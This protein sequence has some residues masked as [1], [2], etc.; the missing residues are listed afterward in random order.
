MARE[1]KVADP[2]VFGG[3]PN[4]PETV[5]LRADQL[6]AMIAE[7]VAKALAAAVPAAAQSNS[8]GDAKALFEQMA[9]SIAEM[10]HQ[11]NR[12]HKPVDP[13]V[14]TARKAGQEKLDALLRQVHEAR[15][16]A[17]DRAYKSE[18]ERHAAITAVTPKYRVISICIFNDDIIAPFVPDPA[19]KK[20]VPVEIY[21]AAEPNDALVPINELAET[22]HAAFRESRGQRSDIEKRAI[23]PA[24]MT[25]SGLVIE[26]GTPPQRRQ[27]DVSPVLRDLDVTTGAAREDISYVSVLGTNHAPFQVN[28]QG[29]TP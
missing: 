7:Q 3:V 24:W 15:K 20:S 21:W 11:T 1:S 16:A 18:V 17:A 13:K 12:T 19:T 14:L 6:Q 23:K 22:I 8:M 28:Y 2:D 29:K 25:E 10:T 9:L 4:E 26:G 5:T 27:L